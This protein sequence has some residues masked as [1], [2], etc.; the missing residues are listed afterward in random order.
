MKIVADVYGVEQAV[1]FDT[2][3]T[4]QYVVLGIF[5]ETVRVPISEKQMEGLTQEAVKQRASGTS[6]MTPFGPDIAGEIPGTPRSEKQASSE[7]EVFSSPM[8]GLEGVDNATPQDEERMERD[9]GLGG[10]FDET[11]EDKES[12]VRAA[13]RGKLTERRSVPTDSAGNPVVAPNA[14]AG[15]PPVSFGNLGAD[16]EGFPQG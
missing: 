2:L 8:S 14:A 13:Q 3:E 6:H 15:L 11:E 10:L 1:D 9:P 5:G 16:D 4:S 12:K 7:D